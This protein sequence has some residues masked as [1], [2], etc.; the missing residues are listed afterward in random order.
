MAH[1]SIDDIRWGD[2][3]ES[4]TSPEII[5]LVKS[6]CMVEYNSEDYVRYLCEVFHDNPEFQSLAREWADE[7]LQHGKSLRKWVERADP[8]FNFDESFKIFTSGYSIP[9]N[10]TE[11]TRGSR[12]GELIARCVV[13]TGT[14]AYYTAIKDLT[15]EPV[16]KELCSKIASDEFRHYK[17]FYSYL[18][19][20]LP[21]EAPSLY[22]RV[23][24]VIGRL[25]ES[26][27]DELAYAFYAAHC[28][29]QGYGDNIY[30]RKEYK[31]AYLSHASS[32][33]RYNH[34]EKMAAMIFKAAGLRTNSW[35]HN[36]SSRIA[37]RFLRLQARDL[38]LS[39]AK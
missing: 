26:G 37:W 18:K 12:C 34:I 16:L 24:I 21:K 25:I 1:W 3:E 36:I 10:V 15:D 31:K 9:K 33:Y 4:K 35:L 2:F 30:D 7:E 8:G 11:S 32:I 13:E 27:D 6:A 19:N 39:T 14:S 38:R 28:T 5:S 22:S 20:Y 29:G 23:K 17:L